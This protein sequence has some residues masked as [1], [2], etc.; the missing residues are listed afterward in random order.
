LP[1]PNSKTEGPEGEFL[2]RVNLCTELRIGG[3]EYASPGHTFE[4]CLRSWC[5]QKP[6]APISGQPFYLG[7]REL[8]PPT[9]LEAV[10][11]L[12]LGN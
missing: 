1:A 11:V 5:L 9:C 12:A 8:A 7:E 4:S 6:T 2:G 3:T 10:E